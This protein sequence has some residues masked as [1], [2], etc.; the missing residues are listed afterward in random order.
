M[1]VY[2]PKCATLAINLNSQRFSG[3]RRI[4]AKYK[5]KCAYGKVAPPELVLKQALALSWRG[6]FSWFDPFQHN[7]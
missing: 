3:S 6:V 5:R 1:D 7:Q 4:A 2:T